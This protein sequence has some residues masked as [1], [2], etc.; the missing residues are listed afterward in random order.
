MAQ[1]NIKVQFEQ[2]TLDFLCSED[3]DVIS[4]AKKNGIDLPN[5]CCSGVCTSCASIILEGSVEQEDAMGLN[6]DLKEKGFA[7]LCVAYPK[8]DLHVVIGEKV[9]DSLYNDQ[10]GKYQK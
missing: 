5:S 3:Q 2:K 10:F 6:D 1:Y 8:S 7:L 9:E 4:A